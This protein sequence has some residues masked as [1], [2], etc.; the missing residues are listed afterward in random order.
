MA[1][2][3]KDEKLE[4][5]EE[6][7][8]GEVV[9]ATEPDIEPWAEE[10]VTD[11]DFAD[12]PKDVSALNYGDLVSGVSGKPIGKLSDNDIKKELSEISNGLEMLVEKGEDPLTD[13]A[14]AVKLANGLKY[15]VSSKEDMGKKSICLYAQVKG[16]ETGK[17]ILEVP[18]VGEGAAKAVCLALI[19][20]YNSKAS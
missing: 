4:V 13:K 19:A 20:A 14:V 5:V 8:E 11:E 3:K 10:P 2:K 12:E 18:F 1:K 9:E 15:T 16:W 17:F 7:T 6:V